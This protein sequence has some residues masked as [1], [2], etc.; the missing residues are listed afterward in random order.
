MST[1]LAVALNR[2][3][4]GLDTVNEFRIET[5]GSQAQY[6]RPATVT[7]VTKSGTNSFH[8]TA[9]KHTAITPAGLRARQRQDGA[10]A[11]KLIRNEFGVSAGGPVLLPKLY[12]GRDKTFWFF[13]Y[14]G[15]RQRQSVFYRAEVPTADMWTGNFNNI[16]DS[17]GRQNEHL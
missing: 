10:T 13:A 9:L 6:S 4:P 16:V 1:A 17:Q 3:Q 2:V 11:P 5:V 7:L 12:N 15:L 8:G 14:E